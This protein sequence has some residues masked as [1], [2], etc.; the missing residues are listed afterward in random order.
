M[1]NIK[2]FKAPNCPFCNK[3]T[4]SMVIQHEDKSGVMCGWT[5]NC[6]DLKKLEDERFDGFLIQIHHQFKNGT[7]NI[8]SQIKVNQFNINE[9]IN[10]E[11]EKL[12]KTH[13][14]PNGAKWMICEE[15]S[16]F[17]VYQKKGNNV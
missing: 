6:E 7:S 1:K 15:G 11:M 2:E 9:K 8:Y 17:F 10:N 16:N 4:I 12:Y 14:L 13:P 3:K 5:C